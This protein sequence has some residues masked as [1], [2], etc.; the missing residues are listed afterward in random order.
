MQGN[1]MKTSHAVQFIAVRDSR[2]R[3]I[4]GLYT[5]N[6]R[7]NGLLWAAGAGDK[8]IP[9]RFPL[10]DPAGVACTN[11]AQAKDAF[12]LLRGARQEAAL[13][14]AGRKPGFSS[15]SDQYLLRASTLAKKT[16]TVQNETQA[17]AR[18]KSHLG[19]TMV[20]WADKDGGILIGKV[21]GHLLDSHRQKM[22]A[23]LTIGLAIVP[24]VAKAG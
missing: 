24:D 19:S 14:M 1:E 17:L 10:N 8:K 18:W 7:F 23:K 5:R 16:G 22:A 6:G 12:D 20:D 13:P 11:L 2:N 15:W 3:R 4:S 9:R 21:Y